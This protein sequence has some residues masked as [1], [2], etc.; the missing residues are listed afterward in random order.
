MNDAGFWQTLH[1]ELAGGEG[2]ALFNSISSR[3]DEKAVAIVSKRYQILSIG[4]C[5]EYWILQRWFLLAVD[6]IWP[7][8][9]VLPPQI[10][11]LLITFSVRNSSG[12]NSGTFNRVASYHHKSTRNGK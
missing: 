1:L 10:Q 8:K 4:V 12:M 7:V 11:K 2:S 3:G 9:E 6:R 5:D